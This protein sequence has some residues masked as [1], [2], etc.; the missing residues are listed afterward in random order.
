MVCSVISKVSVLVTQHTCSY[1][2]RL[3]L[4]LMAGL[5]NSVQILAILTQVV[6]CKVHVLNSKR[7]KLI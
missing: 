7:P 6:M 2:M 3:C 4:L 1:S 5:C